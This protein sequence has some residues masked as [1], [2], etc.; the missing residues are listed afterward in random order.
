M[1]KLRMS[2]LQHTLWST[3]TQ[4][5]KLDIARTCNFQGTNFD[6]E[7]FVLEDRCAQ[8]NNIKMAIKDI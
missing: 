7:N 5:K 2:S 3:N 4:K 6:V 8:N 1:E